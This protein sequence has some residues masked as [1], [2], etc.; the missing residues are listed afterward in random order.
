MS[1]RCLPVEISVLIR[2]EPAATGDMGAFKFEFRGLSDEVISNL[3]CI[4]FVEIKS[5]RSEVWLTT[6]DI[7][8]NEIHT[9]R[10]ALIESLDFLERDWAAGGIQ[11]ETEIA[12]AT[13]AGDACF[14]TLVRLHPAGGRSV[15]PSTLH[16]YN[17]PKLLRELFSLIA[18]VPRNSPPIILVEGKWASD[19]PWQALPLVELVTDQPMDPAAPFGKFLGTHFVVQRKSVE[20]EPAEALTIENRDAP[21]RMKFFQNRSLKACIKEADYLRQAESKNQIDLQGT[22]WP[23]DRRQ[24]EEYVRLAIDHNTIVASDGAIVQGNPDHVHHYSC[25]HKF[26]S[27]DAGS[28]PH[29]TLY[30]QGEDSADELTVA[31]QRIAAELHHAKPGCLLA[32]LNACETGRDA[33]IHSELSGLRGWM[34]RS[35]D[36]KA[37]IASETRIMDSSCGELSVSFYRH[38]FGGEDSAHALFRAISEAAKRGDPTCLLFALHGD[39]R[40]RIRQPFK[41]DA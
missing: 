20:T 35:L 22:P 12:H 6:E 28:S 19:V 5:G 3:D 33:D 16:R 27:P 23:V 40:V 21:V 31:V 8:L 4:P 34:L 38:F 9:A 14:N 36:F 30:L 37:V 11:I 13:R 2:Y 18:G 10:K 7:T 24:P 39:G 32:F 25:H 26:S 1:A 17:L 29:P 41:M 15:P